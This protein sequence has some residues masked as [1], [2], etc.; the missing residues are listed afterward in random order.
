MRH[1]LTRVDVDVTLESTMGNTALHFAAFAGSANI[2]GQL[3]AVPGIRPDTEN[4]LNMTALDYAGEF[5]HDHVVRLFGPN[6]KA[7]TSARQDWSFS[8]LFL[9]PY[10]TF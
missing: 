7:K 9:F 6:R 10:S 2:T 4:V 8:S 5:G 3:L 1:L